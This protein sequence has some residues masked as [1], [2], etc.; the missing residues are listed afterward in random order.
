MFDFIAGLIIGTM[1]VGACVYLYSKAYAL[2]Y[3]DGKE[4][5]SDDLWKE[6]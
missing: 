2:G 6:D 5:A 4:D 3:E 1:V